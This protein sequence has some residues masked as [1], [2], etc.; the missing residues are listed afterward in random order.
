VHLHDM[1]GLRRM[2]TH[3]TPSERDRQMRAMTIFVDGSIRAIALFAST[4]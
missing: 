4:A 3:S 2:L 1:V